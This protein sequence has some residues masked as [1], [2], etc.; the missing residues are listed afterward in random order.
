MTFTVFVIYLVLSTVSI[1]SS[2]SIVFRT[3]EIQ[4]EDVYH[5]YNKYYISPCDTWRMEMREYKSM[6]SCTK[7]ISPKD[8]A[9]YSGCSPA[10]GENEEKIKVSYILKET[11][12]K[13]CNKTSP[14]IETCSNLPIYTLTA[15]VALNDPCHPILYLF[16]LILFIVLLMYR[17]IYPT[18]WFFYPTYYYP[19]GSSR[20][21][22][23]SWNRM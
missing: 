17:C 5:E 14:E 23:I 3:H 15:K 9:T 2:E 11:P 16:G 1:V 4:C 13:E 8:G 18:H 20:S 21:S 19:R 12:K 10:F 7:Y 6:V 22:S